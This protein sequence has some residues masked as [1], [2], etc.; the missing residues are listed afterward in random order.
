[1]VCLFEGYGDILHRYRDLVSITKQL[2][3]PLRA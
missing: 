2:L 1:M 3:I